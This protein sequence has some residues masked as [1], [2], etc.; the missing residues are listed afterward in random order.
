MSQYINDS[1]RSRNHVRSVETEHAV[2][3]ARAFLSMDFRNKTELQSFAGDLDDHLRS[4]DLGEVEQN[5]ETC[6]FEHDG[7]GV[8]FD[9]AKRQILT[10]EIGEDGLENAIA[11]AETILEAHAAMLHRLN[12]PEREFYAASNSDWRV[13]HVVHLAKQR[14]KDRS[15]VE[16][17]RD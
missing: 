8:A 15:E 16:K 13:Y 2:A 11:S 17:S 12:Q 10:E 4:Y 14:A 1:Q 5:I 9:E 6:D 3:R 7:S